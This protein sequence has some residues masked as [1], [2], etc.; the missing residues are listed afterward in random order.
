MRLLWPSCPT[1]TS[2]IQ[3]VLLTLLYL[4]STYLVHLYG[5]IFSNLTMFYASR[6]F[7]RYFVVD[8]LL[9]LL[10]HSNDVGELQTIVDGSAISSLGI[11]CRYSDSL[12]WIDKRREYSIGMLVHSLKRPSKSYHFVIFC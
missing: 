2:A 11:P 6:T 10:P 7:V 3:R 5:M 8:Q 9:R 1:E 4:E 12:N